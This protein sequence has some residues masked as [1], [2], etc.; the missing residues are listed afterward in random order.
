MADLPESGPDEPVPH[1]TGE[2]ARGGE[3]VLRS[4]A[5]RLVFIGGLVLAV[6]I[7]IVLRFGGFY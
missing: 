7:V 3:I 1:L 5:R 2:E 6:L 4:R